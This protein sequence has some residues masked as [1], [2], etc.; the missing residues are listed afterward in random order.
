VLDVKLAH[1]VSIGEGARLLS[2]CTKMMR[3]WDER[4]F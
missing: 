2:L 4:R 3:V 1:N